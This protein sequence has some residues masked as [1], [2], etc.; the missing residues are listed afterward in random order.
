MRSPPRL[1]FIF[2]ITTAELQLP[3][4]RRRRTFSLDFR[5]PLPYTKPIPLLDTDSTSAM[6]AFLGH[7]RQPDSVAPVGIRPATTYAS[8]SP[9]R[10]PRASRILSRRNNPQNSLASGNEYAAVGREM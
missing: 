8:S 7:R 3:H 1:N 4:S 2:N 5:R 10:R 6:S 9:H